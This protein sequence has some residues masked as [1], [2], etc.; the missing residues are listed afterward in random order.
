MPTREPFPMHS[1]TKNQQA[2]ST[3][4]TVLT[5]TSFMVAWAHLKVSA[6]LV[7][8]PTPFSIPPTSAE[9]PS[10]AREERSASDGELCEVGEGG[11]GAFCGR[12]W[13]AEGSGQPLQGCAHLQMGPGYHEGCGRQ[14]RR[15][16]RD[17]L[18]VLCW[19]M[20]WKGFPGWLSSLN[21]SRVT[22][23]CSSETDSFSSVVVDFYPTSSAKL[24]IK[25]NIYIISG[26]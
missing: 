20:H 25:E 6:S 5:A 7:R 16:C 12:G 23:L 8:L 11:A 24:G 22:V 10:Y 26:G 9:G 19:R 3:T 4:T 14:H 2:I 21:G 1:P 13:Y 17:R 15:C 18:L